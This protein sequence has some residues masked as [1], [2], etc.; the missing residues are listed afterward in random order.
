[1]AQLQ[2]RTA[3][4]TDVLIVGADSSA[5][6]LAGEIARTGRSVCVVTRG[7]SRARRRWGASGPGSR[8]GPR[9]TRSSPR[10]CATGRGTSPSSI[11][12]STAR[13]LEDLF[14]EKG[15][16]FYY[17]A[18]PAG[19]LVA[20]GAAAGVVF[21]G[22]FGLVA[23]EASCVIDATVDGACLRLG[24]AL[25]AVRRGLQRRLRARREPG[26]ALG[27]PLRRARDR[28]RLGGA[29][30]PLRGL[31]GVRGDA[32]PR[33]RGRLS[34]LPGANLAI[35]ASLLQDMEG[36]S[37]VQGEKLG[38]ERMAEAI[39]IERPAPY[40]GG[41]RA[42]SNGRAGLAQL[43]G[44]SPRPRRQQGRLPR[45]R[46]LS[47]PTD[48]CRLSPASPHPGRGEP[49]APAETWRAAGPGAFC[50]G[51]DAP[52]GP[53]SRHRPPAAGGQRRGRRRRGGGRRHERLP[54]ALAAGAGGGPSL[55]LRGHAAEPVV[56]TP[57]V[58]S[59]SYWFGNGSPWFQKTS[60]ASSPTKSAPGSAGGLRA[61]RAPRLRRGVP[62]DGARRRGLRG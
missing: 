35:R 12:G 24:G 26:P 18:A 53:A 46:P 29:L 30:A 44:C 52:R 19:L 40:E 4:G 9:G 1:M 15:I 38:L 51:G 27:A 39:T 28:H 45:V 62:A 23:L 41:L 17:A 47:E 5:C 32:A 42:S 31:R 21:G 7:S 20:D 56:P 25:A 33:P 6:R 61:A 55:A 57:W 60:R 58:G 50:T 8:P 37:P 11:S 13:S 2:I 22:K 14:L 43:R 49:G 59:R 34:P 36:L 16:R 54:A 10:R 3:G 48:H